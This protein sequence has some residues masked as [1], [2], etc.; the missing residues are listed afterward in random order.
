MNVFEEVLL[1]SEDKPIYAN[2][3]ELSPINGLNMT[4]KEIGMY[5]F[6][7]DELDKGLCM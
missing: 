4:A 5:F 3:Y 6:I 7:A 2:N 1:E